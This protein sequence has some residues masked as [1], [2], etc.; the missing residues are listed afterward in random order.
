MEPDVAV[1]IYESRS[2]VRIYEN[3]LLLNPKCEV[4][5]SFI[6]VF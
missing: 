1:D 5:R 4:C 3:P 6:F 2:T